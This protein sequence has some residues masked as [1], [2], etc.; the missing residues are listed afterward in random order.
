[1]CSKRAGGYLVELKRGDTGRDE[2]PES[3]QRRS[4]HTPSTS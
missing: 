2:L 3:P 4:D 1:M